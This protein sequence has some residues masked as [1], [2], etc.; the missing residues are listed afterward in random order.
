L[1]Q[2]IRYFS[3]LL[4]HSFYGVLWLCF[5]NHNQQLSTLNYRNKLYALIEFPWLKQD[6]RR[7]QTSLTVPPSGELDET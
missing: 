6:N 3:L 5:S 1:R 2:N 7:Q 4:C